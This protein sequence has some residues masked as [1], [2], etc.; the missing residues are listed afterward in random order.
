MYLAVLNIL[1]RGY[2]VLDAVYCHIG[3]FR[4]ILRHGLEYAAG[5]REKARAAVLVGVCLAVKLNARR[6]KPACQLVKGQNRVN[7][8]LVVLR[9]ILFGNAGADKNGLCVRISALYVLAVNLHG[10]E[11][12]CEI[13]QL[14]RKIFLNEQVDGVAAGGDYDISRVA[15]YHVLIFCL[16]Y[17]CADGGLLGVEKAELFYRVAHSVYTHAL[18]VRYKGR[19]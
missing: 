3:V 11:H 4:I 10:G 13:R 5:R 7:Y 9:L 18:I 14:R 8:A 2:A 1:E 6:F 15:V 16:D 12:I 19:G 17:C